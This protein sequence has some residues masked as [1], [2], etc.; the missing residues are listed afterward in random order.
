MYS[1]STIQHYSHTFSLNKNHRNFGMES[2]IKKIKRSLESALEW[3]SNDVII[4]EIT[5]LLVYACMIRKV[6]A[7][8]T[9]PVWVFTWT[10]D[11]S[12]GEFRIESSTVTIAK[13]TEKQ[14]LIFELMVKGHVMNKMT[15]L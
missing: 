14:P 4:S 8:L 12:I 5:R 1:Y 2:P 15:P 9:V 10:W 11:A 7:F 3:L 6:Y 13:E